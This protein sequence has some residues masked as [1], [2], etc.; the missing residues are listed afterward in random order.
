MLTM[1]MSKEKH[2]KIIFILLV[3]QVMVGTQKTFCEQKTHSHNLA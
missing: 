1:S 3:Y 2:M